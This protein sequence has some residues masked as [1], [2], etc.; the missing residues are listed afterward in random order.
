PMLGWRPTLTAYEIQAVSAGEDAQG[1]VIVRCRRST[2]EA[3]VS[4]AT[5]HGLS[6]NII[7][8]SL[9]G[10]LGAVNK[11]IARPVAREVLA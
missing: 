9:E 7:E 6:T 4:P 2:D 1:R 8:A 3:E 10:Y 11:L 5:G